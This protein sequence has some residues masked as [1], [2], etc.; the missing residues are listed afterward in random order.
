MK[1]KSSADGDKRHP[2]QDEVS[3]AIQRFAMEPDQFVILERAPEEY[4]QISGGQLEYRDATG[5]YRADSQITEKI[6][7]RI[8]IAFLD[9]GDA[10][11]GIVPWRSAEE[12]LHREFADRARQR[13]S[14]L[15]WGIALIALLLVGAG[16]W[17]W[18]QR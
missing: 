2:T 13:N 16:I 3:N 17:F 5:H 18:S 8:F 14:P 1:L 10:W 6:A 15:N 9:G 4:V 11:R 12:A 7:E